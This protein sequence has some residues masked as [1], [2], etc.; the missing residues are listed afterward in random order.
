M[1]TSYFAEQEGNEQG[2][3]DASPRMDSG[4]A[5]H[6]VDRNLPDRVCTAAI[7]PSLMRGLSSP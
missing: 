3:L 7:L 2:Y 6:E 4:A 5:Q 1:Q